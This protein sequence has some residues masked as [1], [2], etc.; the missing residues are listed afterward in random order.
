MQRA[1]AANPETLT[2]QRCPTAVHPL[3]FEMLGGFEKDGNISHF[4]Q[5]AQTAFRWGCAAVHRACLV[6]CPPQAAALAASAPS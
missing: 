6:N 5:Y 2:P 4:V 3:W 1:S